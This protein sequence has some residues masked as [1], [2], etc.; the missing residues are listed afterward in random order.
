MLHVWQ[1]SMDPAW[2]WTY[3]WTCAV[4]SMRPGLQASFC[5]LSHLPREHWDQCRS[6]N[7]I[8]EGCFEISL[9][10]SDVNPI[11]QNED[12]YWVITG[13]AGA[14]FSSVTHS[15][16]TLCDPMDCSTPGL[17][18]HYYF[19]ELVQTRI[20]RVGDA[21]QPSHPLSS[22]SPPAF[23]PSQHQGLFQWVNSLHQVTKVL[24]FPLQH[25]SLQGIFRTDFLSDSLVWS[26]SSPRDS[27]ESSP[28]P[29]F[30]SI[31]SL[32]LGFL[33]SPTLTSIHDHWKNH[34]L[35]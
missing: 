25:Q 17:P 8:P 34:S 2:R 19:L 15:S 9:I 4:T 13:R 6:R 14:W 18:V 23:N 28:T 26:P 30:K 12:F 29:Q 27:Q 35:D 3:F 1:S 7:Q 11:K 20:H 33:Y 31:I 5:G 10:E 21:I 22:P 24:E 32:V 16:P